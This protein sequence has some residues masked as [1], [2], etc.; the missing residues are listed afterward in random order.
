MEQKS[1]I[2]PY[3]IKALRLALGWSQSQ[4]ADYIVVN[5]RTVGNWE[6]GSAFPNE[7][8]DAIL[9]QLNNKLSNLP[10]PTERMDFGD[11]LALTVIT[12]GTLAAL[13]FIFRGSTNE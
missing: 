2:T 9:K 5:Y 3:Q 4:L 10:E 6:S 11:K 7:M 8:Q 12:A 13:A 1:I